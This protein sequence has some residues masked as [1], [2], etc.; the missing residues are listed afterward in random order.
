M[1]AMAPVAAAALVRALSRQFSHA[2]ITLDSQQGS[3][4]SDSMTLRCGWR[5]RQRGAVLE[6]TVAV[7]RCSLQLVC[8]AAGA[9]AHKV[10]SRVRHFAG[11][12]GLP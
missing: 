2:F 12:S 5:S 8:G 9:A 6:C 3:P 4:F 7:L 11:L 10:V 1:R